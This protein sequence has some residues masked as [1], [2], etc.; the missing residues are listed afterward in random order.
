MFRTRM[1]PSRAPVR[2]GARL[3]KGRRISSRHRQGEYLPYDGVISPSKTEDILVVCCRYKEGKWIRS[4]KLA[5][6]FHSMMPRLYHEIFDVLH[7]AFEGSPVTRPSTRMADFE[8]LGCFIAR[9]AGYGADGFA[10]LLR[11]ALDGVTL[12][13]F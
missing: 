4:G 13:S 9:H 12:D 10:G 5:S 2:N 8:M 3:P 11:S 6:E 7:R 1:I